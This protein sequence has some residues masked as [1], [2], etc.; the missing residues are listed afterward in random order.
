MSVRQ[1]KDKEEWTRDGRSWIYEGRY[2]GV[3]YKSKKYKTKNEARVAERDFLNE[4][5]KKHPS[6]DDMTLEDLCLDHY[7]NHK[8]EVKKTTVY[9]YENKM[10]HLECIKNIKISNL[11]LK[12]I[13]YWKDEMNKTDRATNT[14]NDSLKYLK[15]VL[16]YG[17][18]MYNFNYPFY[19]S[20]ENFKNLNEI[21]REMEFYTYEE[22]TKFISVEK[23][24]KFIAAYETLYYC[25]LRLGELRALTWK[26]VDFKKKILHIIQ[27]VTNQKG[28]SGKWEIVT[29]KTKS[30]Y[31]TIPIPDILINHLLTY[32]EQFKGYY[33]FTE[34]WFVFGNVN[35][36]HPD[37]LRNRRK[38]N[39]E[40]A[41]VKII[42]IHDFRHSCASFLISRGANVMVV[43]KYLGHSKID[44]T[45]NTYTHLFN[46]D[47]EKVVNIFNEEVKLQLNYV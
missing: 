26:N 46:K 25:G 29:P 30:S 9:N 1:I 14:K 36:L 47:L 4:V 11:S 18:R 35:P 39:A 15:S 31:R 3:R 19:D 38:K 7:K 45:L 22:F 13:Q 21:K 41:G 33:G 12:D 43:A 34:D 17:R 42:R 27:N 24:I 6:S 44:E 20:I 23:D 10:K 40:L 37:V 5:D 2:K 16:N 28:E 32:K 8:A